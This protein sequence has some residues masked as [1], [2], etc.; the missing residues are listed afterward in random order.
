[1]ADRIEVWAQALLDIA[2][3]RRPPD[4]V[5][6][7][8][9][10]FARIVEGNDELRMALSNPGQSGRAPRRRSSTTCS[11]TARCR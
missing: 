2:V 10:R 6:D 5:E 11:R 9:F 3:G 1:M 7:E 4:E 8:L